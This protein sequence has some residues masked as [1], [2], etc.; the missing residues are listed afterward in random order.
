MCICMYVNVYMYD[1]TYPRPSSDHAA[2]WMPSAVRN[3]M[4]VISSWIIEA[5]TAYVT[6]DH[7][8]LDCIEE[9]SIVPSGSIPFTAPRFP[10]FTFMTL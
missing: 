6:P 1:M 9:K 7:I 10:S 5:A 3:A 8:S 2:S 4:S